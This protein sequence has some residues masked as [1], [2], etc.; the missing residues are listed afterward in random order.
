MQYIS[1]TFTRF[2]LLTICCQIAEAELLLG[3]YSRPPTSLYLH[4]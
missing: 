1:V 4:F 2:E 3:H